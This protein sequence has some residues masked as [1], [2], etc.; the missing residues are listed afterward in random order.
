MS[1]PK[2]Q[3]RVK[4]FEE[5]RGTEALLK[6]GLSTL[7]RL[8]VDKGVFTAKELKE[9]LFAEMDK[10]EGKDPDGVPF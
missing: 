4:K 7:N 2:K 6:A 5:D 1:E 9:A 8:L 3:S 10:V